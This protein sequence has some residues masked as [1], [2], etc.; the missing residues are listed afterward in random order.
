MRIRDIIADLIGVICIFGSGYGL[1]LL[2]HG[3]GF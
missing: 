3:L 2:G 1:L